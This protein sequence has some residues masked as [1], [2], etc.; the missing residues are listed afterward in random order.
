L[1][2]FIRFCGTAMP[3]LVN[4]LGVNGPRWNP[5]AV[6]AIDLEEKSWAHSLIDQSKFLQRFLKVE[7]RLAQNAT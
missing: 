4:D 6:T 2:G 5:D 7:V 3:R 1:D